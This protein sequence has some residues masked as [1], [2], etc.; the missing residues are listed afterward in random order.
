MLLDFVWIDLPTTVN[1]RKSA[2][3]STIQQSKGALDLRVSGLNDVL[4]P[5]DGHKCGEQR[6]E[7]DYSSSKPKVS[8]ASRI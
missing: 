4:P 5:P 8:Y 1:G 3:I 6:N 7:I 2:N